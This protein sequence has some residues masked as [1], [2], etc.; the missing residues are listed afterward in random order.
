MAEGDEKHWIL[1][2]FIPLRVV[3]A[4]RADVAREVHDLV[5]SSFV[6]SDRACS[7]A[8]KAFASSEVDC[9]ARK[10]EYRLR[11]ELT[12]RRE[13][14]DDAALHPHKA[15]GLRIRVN[16]R[17]GARSVPSASSAANLP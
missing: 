11:E 16:D 7:D 9:A 3:S 15:G 13:P 5:F 8:H 17:R 1:V 6:R 12:T 10:W 4:L 2:V 14:Q